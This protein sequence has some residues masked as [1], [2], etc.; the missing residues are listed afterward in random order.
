[1]GTRA[2]WVFVGAA[3]L[4][5]CP[6]D[7]DGTTDTDDTDV[8]VVPVS[9]EVTSTLPTVIDEDTE[10]T[11]DW[12]I[13][14]TGVTVI[15]TNVHCCPAAEPECAPASEGGTRLDS[16]V[17][18]IDG[19]GDGMPGNYTGALTIPEPGDYACSV[20]SKVQEPDLPEASN[21]HEAF[22]LTVTDVAE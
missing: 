3:L 1:M 16:P 4:T 20:H 11:V 13:A 14:G 8:A 12:T 21:Y 17:S 5:G 15:H 9:V 6:T 2:F 18:G 7:D 10:F 22:D 19:G